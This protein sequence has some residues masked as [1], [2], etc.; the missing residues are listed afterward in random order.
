ME[1]AKS[2]LQKNLESQGWRFLTLEDPGTESIRNEDGTY[3]HLFVE[4]KHDLEI[5]ASY[6]RDFNFKDVYVTDNLTDNDSNLRAVYV[7]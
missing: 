6:L 7:K 2:K 5:R 3:D 1:E 4:R